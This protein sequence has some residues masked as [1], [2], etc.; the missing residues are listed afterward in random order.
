MTAVLDLF[1]QLIARA[2]PTVVSD[3]ERNVLRVP[4]TV[5]S[6]V[7]QDTLAHAEGGLVD[8]AALRPRVSVFMGPGSTFRG[9]A[10]GLLPLYIG[11]A[12]TG[13][14]AP[15]RDELARALVVYNQHY[16]PGKTFDEYRVG[17][18]L[19]LPIE[20]DAATGGW[21]ID[22]DNV[23]LLAAGFDGAWLSRLTTPVPGLDVV[24]AAALPG[25]VATIVSDHAGTDALAG[26]LLRRTLTNPY[27]AVFDLYESLRQVESSTTGS[28]FT[29]SLTIMSSLVDHQA[30][31]LAATSAGNG[32]LRR[33]SSAL[34]DA[35][36]TLDATGKASLARAAAMLDGALWT[37]SGTTRA[38]VPFHELPQTAAQRKDLGAVPGGPHLSAHDPAGGAHVVVFGR[39]V[40]VGHAV[41][42]STKE[43]WDAVYVGPARSRPGWP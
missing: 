1:M 30:A 31:L 19:P 2:T 4:L 39:D 3:E 16:L 42:P 20:I 8:D 38:R 18:R 37:S 5:P 27:A 23:R 41:G 36:S 22:A 34:G 14:P 32:I 28:A 17:L 40:A 9:A 29:V 10:E 24:D 13:A 25:T 35:P 12:T 6:S 21:I 33:L 26:E 43:T 7:R 11:A 15:T